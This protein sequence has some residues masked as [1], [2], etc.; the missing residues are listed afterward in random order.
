MDWNGAVFTFIME[1]PRT[2][3]ISVRFLDVILSRCVML[4]T[5]LHLVPRSKIVELYL[6]S[7]IHLHMVL[8]DASLWTG[9]SSSLRLPVLNRISYKL[10]H[11]M[12]CTVAFIKLIQ[13]AGWLACNFVISF[14]RPCVCKVKCISEFEWKQLKVQVLFCSHNHS[15]EEYFFL[16]LV[17]GETMPADLREG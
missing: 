4:T 12:V 14:N 5:N 8:C 9:T 1:H 2:I 11:I 15:H 10:L 17:S 6:H 13:D 16:R 3:G 7:P